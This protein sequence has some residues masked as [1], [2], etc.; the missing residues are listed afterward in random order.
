MM[1]STP[2]LVQIELQPHTQPQPEIRSRRGKT[3]GQVLS[4]SNYSGPPGVEVENLIIDR[5]ASTVSEPEQTFVPQNGT[6]SD[7]RI[8]RQRSRD[9]EQGS[10][11]SMR[12]TLVP[13]VAHITS[14]LSDSRPTTD[15]SAQPSHRPQASRKRTAAPTKP[16]TYDQDPAD[17]FDSMATCLASFP[18][19]GTDRAEQS[20]CHWR[21]TIARST[22]A[23]R[24][25]S[26]SPPRSRSPG[27]VHAVRSDYCRPSYDKLREATSAKFRPETSFIDMQHESRSKELLDY[28]QSLS[29]ATSSDPGLWKEGACQASRSGSVNLN[30]LTKNGTQMFLRSYNGE[31][32]FSG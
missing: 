22:T 1:L 23:L 11:G 29:M 24:K 12:E 17:C 32:Q 4:A 26:T 6:T 9:S 5:T 16:S 8:T 10:R 7:S 13:A 30:L 18:G 21:N 28:L 14:D 20:L 15:L 25:F 27:S 2:P 31:G 3:S 19:I